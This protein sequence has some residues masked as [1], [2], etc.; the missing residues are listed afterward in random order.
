M[1]VLVFLPEWEHLC[2]YWP[3]Y[4]FSDSSQ[5]L[6]QVWSRGFPSVLIYSWDL[7]AAVSIYFLYW[8]YTALLADQYMANSL[9][10]LAVFLE[11]RFYS[12]ITIGQKQEAQEWLLI[13]SIAE[14]KKESHYFF[15]CGK[16]GG[17]RQARSKNKVDFLS[18]S[19]VIRAPL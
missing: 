8:C 19:C 15:C 6:C 7:T 3:F 18:Y 13:F 4:L 11:I 17:G 14:P 10:Y 16:G 5:E 12:I 1:T 9:T 2:I